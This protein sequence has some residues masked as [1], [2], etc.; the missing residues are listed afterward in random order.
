[1]S[2]LIL[3]IMEKLNLLNFLEMLCPLFISSVIQLNLAFSLLFL[4]NYKKK[5]GMNP[6]IV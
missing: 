2:K 6:N 3:I 4:V 5:H 1:M